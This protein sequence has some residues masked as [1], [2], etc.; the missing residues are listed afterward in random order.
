MKKPLTASI[1]YS[2]AVLF[3]MLRMRLA[4]AMYSVNMLV[5]AKVSLDRVN[6][7]L[8]TVMWSSI[9]GPVLLTGVHRRSS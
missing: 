9:S 7:F 6:K 8:R 4:R 2:S 1:V 5:M 3:D